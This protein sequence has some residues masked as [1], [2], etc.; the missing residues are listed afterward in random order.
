[1]DEKQRKHS[2]H[3]GAVA[4]HELVVEAAGGEG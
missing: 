3:E 1:M 4:M 2:L